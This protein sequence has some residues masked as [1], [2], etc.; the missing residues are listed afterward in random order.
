[1]RQPFGTIVPY[2]LTFK[3]NR[4]KKREKYRTSGTD[5]WR[6]QNV[7]N[8]PTTKSKKT[9]LLQHQIV[10]LLQQ[11]HKL[12]QF[13]SAIY[14]WSR[15]DFNDGCRGISFLRYVFSLW[16]SLFMDWWLSLVVVKRWWV[17]FSRICVR[18]NSWPSRIIIH[19][20]L[21]RLQIFLM[22]RIE[23]VKL[24]NGWLA[25]QPGRALKKTDTTG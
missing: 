12:D 8:Y 1:M 10:L 21:T 13:I 3:K 5:L 16:H 22:G 18:S 20:A 25:V 9:F 14:I 17:D 4:I 24:A 2:V 11:T 23:R 6:G 7:L 15:I 19:A